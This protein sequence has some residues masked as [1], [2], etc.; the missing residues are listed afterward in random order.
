MRLDPG[1]RFGS[2][3]AFA[4]PTPGQIWKMT[5]SS[6]GE[7]AS[8]EF[9]SKELDDFMAKQPDEIV[10]KGLTGALDSLRAKKRRSS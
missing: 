4:L 6:H 7:S 5:L 10:S 1:P 9:P 8:V 3:E 2:M